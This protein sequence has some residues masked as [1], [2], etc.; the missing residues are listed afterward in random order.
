[1]IGVRLAVFAADAALQVGNA[2]GRDKISSNYWTQYIGKILTWKTENVN[3]F[4]IGHLF[5]KRLMK[6]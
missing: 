4:Q 3:G 1:M 2:T 5:R 6:A